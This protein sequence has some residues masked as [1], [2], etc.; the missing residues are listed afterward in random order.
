[1]NSNNEYMAFLY[2]EKKSLSWSKKKLDIPTINILPTKQYEVMSILK[3][4]V[5][6]LHL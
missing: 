5:P 6:A 2:H 4:K 3:K 1:M